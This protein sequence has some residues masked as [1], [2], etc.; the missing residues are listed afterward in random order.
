MGLKTIRYKSKKEGS[1]FGVKTVV[2][3]DTTKKRFGD[4]RYADGLFKDVKDAFLT[5]GKKV[6]K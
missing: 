3:S 2:G 4:S 1:K 5:V 6:F